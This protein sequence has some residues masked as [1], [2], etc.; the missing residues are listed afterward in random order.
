M[1]GYLTSI[2]STINC[3]ENEIIYIENTML[4]FDLS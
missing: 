1:T 3:E 2:F 4:S